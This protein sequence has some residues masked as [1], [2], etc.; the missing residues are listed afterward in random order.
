MP[1]AHQAITRDANEVILCRQTFIGRVSFSPHYRRCLHRFLTWR[2]LVLGSLFR[3][4]ATFCGL[5]WHRFGL[6][7]RAGY[8]YCWS[9]YSYHCSKSLKVYRRY[10]RIIQ[11]HRAELQVSM[12]IVC[13]WFAIMSLSY[14][15]RHP[16][17]S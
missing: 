15:L 13:S 6:G 1:C 4:P 11:R 10:F 16:R 17:A 14:S 8:S 2:V 12:Y 3:P 5:C 9:C 7:W